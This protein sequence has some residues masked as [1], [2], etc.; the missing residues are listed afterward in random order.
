MKLLL[1]NSQDSWC[2]LTVVKKWF[3]LQNLE[4]VFEDDE[5]GIVSEPINRLFTFVRFNDRKIHYYDLHEL[6]AKSELGFELFLQ[7]PTE[8]EGYRGVEFN[9]AEWDIFELEDGREIVVEKGKWR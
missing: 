5:M 9:F 4:L 3:E 7:Y 2:G 6:V 8:F 1:K